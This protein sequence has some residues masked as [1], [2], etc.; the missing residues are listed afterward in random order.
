MRRN[1]T[2]IDSRQVVTDYFCSDY[3][4]WAA[5][6]NPHDDQIDPADSALY[7]AHNFYAAFFADLRKATHEIIIVSP[8][9]TANRAQQFFDLLRSKIALGVAVRVFTQT[10]RDGTGEMSRQA[11]MVIEELKRINVQVVERRGLH[12]KFAFIDRKVAWEGSLNILSQSAGRTTEHMRRLPF[13]TTCD[14][15]I[16]LHQLG[17]DAEVEPGSRGKIRTDRQCEVH[18][19]P[20]VLVPGPYGLFLGCQEYPRC[21]I[22]YRIGQGDRI[23]TDAKCPGKDGVACDQTMFAVRGRYGVYLKCF[24]P[25]CNGTQKIAT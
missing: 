18:H 6:L 24:S 10:V 20:M 16:K 2:V 22:H 13:A 1:G 8:F 3:E 23:K 4:R 9:L 12:Q 17:S 5:L 19:T 11:K 21:N 14:E 7:T 15:L 25:G